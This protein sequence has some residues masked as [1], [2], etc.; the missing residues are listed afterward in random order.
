MLSLRILDTLHV[1]LTTHAMYF[2][3]VDMSGDLAGALVHSVW[4]VPVKRKRI[5]GH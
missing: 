4:Y 3:L 2:Y 5:Q 1:V